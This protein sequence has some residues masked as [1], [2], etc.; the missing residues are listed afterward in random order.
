MDA[1]AKAALKLQGLSMLAGF[2]AEFAGILSS[3]QALLS[4][5]GYSTSIIAQ[6]QQDYTDQKQLAKYFLGLN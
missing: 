6:Y 3:F 5:N 2:D 4:T 1:Q